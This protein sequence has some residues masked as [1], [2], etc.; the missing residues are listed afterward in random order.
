[1][2]LLFQLLAARRLTVILCAPF[3]ALAGFCHAEENKFQFSIVQSSATST[4]SSD[5]GAFVSIPISNDSQMVV[6][7]RLLVNDEPCEAAQEHALTLLFDHFDRNQDDTICAEESR[8]LPDLSHTVQLLWNPL[9]APRMLDRSDSEALS[10]ASRRALIDWYRQQRLRCLHV[11]FGRDHASGP[12]S[13]RLKEIVKTLPMN[14]DAKRAN[15]VAVERFKHLDENFDGYLSADE[16]IRDAIYPSTSASNPLAPATDRVAMTRWNVNVVRSLEPSTKECSTGFQ[17][18]GELGDTTVLVRYDG[19]S[20]VDEFAR[21][22]DFLSNLF[23]ELDIDRND[24]LSQDELSAKTAR[25]MRTYVPFADADRDQILSRSELDVW[26]RLW[27][28]LASTQWQLSIVDQTIGLWERFDI[29]QDGRLSVVE[30]Y[31]GVERPYTIESESQQ[32]A[33]EERQLRVTISA[34]R[35]CALTGT[36]DRSGPAWFRAADANADGVVQKDEFV[37]PLTIFD[38]LDANGDGM[39]DASESLVGVPLQ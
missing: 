11:G 19:G 4:N 22:Q 28:R 23:D 15:E 6:E 31:Q 7:V 39:I 18:L 25:L 38:R 21:S 8:F 36:I 34:G 3:A 20:L 1:M 9:G 5:A 17:R 26:L 37:G 12:L 27:Q 30:W 10:F 29:D 2:M 24:R 14:Q 33:G 13:E 16:L 32:E 35:P